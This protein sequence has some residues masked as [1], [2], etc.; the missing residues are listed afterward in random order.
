MDSKAILATLTVVVSFGLLGIYVFRDQAPDVV[1]VAIAAG[2]ISGVLSYYFGA[3][4]G[5]VTGL[6]SAATNISNLA[7]QL[8][9]QAIEKRAQPAAAVVVAT[10]APASTDTAPSA[11]A[12]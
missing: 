12:P 2:A 3:H 1:I 6:A 8:A 11:S 7:A 4:N 5:A 9:S 10:P